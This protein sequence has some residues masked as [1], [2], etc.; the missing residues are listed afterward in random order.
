M[1][2]CIKQKAYLFG[3]S[4]HTGKLSHALYF[5]NY[6][7]FMLFL[8]IT[9]LAI[10]I[11]QNNIF[12]YLSKLVKN[13]L[14]CL[15]YTLNADVSKH[16]FYFKYKTKLLFSINILNYPL[17]YWNYTQINIYI[18]TVY[19]YFSHE[20]LD[21]AGWLVV[22]IP[23]DNQRVK[24][25]GTSWLVNAAYAGNELTALHLHGWL[26]F[27][28]DSCSALSEFLWNPPPSPAPPV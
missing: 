20:T 16:L 5:S 9:L 13:P 22:N 19:I 6:V 17:L 4:C 10:S 1:S 26:A 21:G 12:V 15:K 27:T 7:F 24:R 11:M 14:S 23:D 8:N 25:L 3:A 28:W 2:N 18:H